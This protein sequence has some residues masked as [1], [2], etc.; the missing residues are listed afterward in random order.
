[1][2]HVHILGWHDRRIRRLASKSAQQF[3]PQS[4]SRSERLRLQAGWPGSVPNGS[5]YLAVSELF[6]AVGPPQEETAPTHVSP[7]DESHRELEA[8]PEYVDEHIDILRGRDA[9]EQDDVAVGSES[10]GDDACAGDKRLSVRVVGGVD[11][12]PRKRL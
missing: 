3:L 1:M 2:K 8:R 10:F 5:L 6:P 11:F 9:A 7:P 4:D 12:G